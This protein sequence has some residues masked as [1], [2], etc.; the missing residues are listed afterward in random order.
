MVDDV[1]PAVSPDRA[2]R[3][4]YFDDDFEHFVGQFSPLLWLETHLLCDVGIP[5]WALINLLRNLY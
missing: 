1:T 4:M 3:D 5:S 2:E